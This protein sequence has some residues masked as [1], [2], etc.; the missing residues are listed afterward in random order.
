MH[1]ITYAVLGAGAIAM[2]FP[3]GW[4]VLTSLK[5]NSEIIA[6]GSP[7]FPKSP[8]WDNYWRA[9]TSLPFGR[10]ALNTVVITAFTIVGALVSNTLVAYGFA[11]FRVRENNILFMVLLATMM[12]PGA[13]TMIPQFIL[14]K[15]IGW[16]NTYFPLIVPAFFGNAFF[17]FLLRQFFRTIPRDFEEAARL[18]GLGPFGV[19]IRIVL[20]LTL[21]VLTTVAIF[22][23]NGAWNDFMTPLIYLNDSSMYTLSLGINFFKGGAGI[24]EVPQWNYLMAASTISLLPSLVL[25]FFGQKYFIEG[26]SI[27]S[28][29]K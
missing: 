21:P 7:W 29:I 26:I 17:I 3:L 14:F 11:R 13:V 4:M 23:F 19:L 18:D 24:T 27:S 12:L 22:Q 28:G 5:T 1:T 10:W 20:P 16:V 9:F 15:D 8:Q 6:V 2:L 25:F